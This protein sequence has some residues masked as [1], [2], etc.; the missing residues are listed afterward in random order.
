MMTLVFIAG[1]GLGSV[2]TVVAGLWTL[3][4]AAK[5]TKSAQQKFNDVT[6]KLMRER[7]EQEARSANALEMIAKTVAVHALK[8]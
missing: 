2:I 8:G 6:E 4:V 3:R 7:N 5:D 1:M